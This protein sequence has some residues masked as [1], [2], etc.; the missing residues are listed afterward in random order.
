MYKI[1]LLIDISEDYGKSLL[2][3]VTKYSKENGPWIFCRMPLHYREDLSMDNL[4]K[5]A[6]EWKA[7]GIIAQ[8]YNTADIK[9]LKETNI[10]VIVEDFKERFTEFPNITG[11]YFETGQMGAKYFINKGYKNFAFYGFNDIVWSRERAEGYEDYIVKQGGKVH[12]FK[13]HKILSRELWYYKP[14]ALSKWLTS[15]P[16]PIA[17]M[18][19][20]DERAQYITGACKQSKIKIPEEVSV[21]G[22]DND[23]LT[24]NLSDPPL[25]SIGLD[26]E[27]GG[28]ETAKLM[29]FLIENKDQEP[30]D[31]IVKPTTIYTRQS[32]DIC[33]TTDAQIAMALNFIHQNIENNINV[34]DV[35][36]KVSISRRALE[37]RFLEVTG[38]AVY[39]YIC[40]LRIEKFSDKLLESEKSI[41]EIAIE[42]GFNDNK[43][44]SRL[45]KQINGC[46]PLQYRKANAK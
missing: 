36:K 38:S 1:I 12:F 37:K 10:P 8:L 4:I 18:A 34:I 16:K 30:Y 25:S 39:K 21:L 17:I 22:V 31:I 19:C 6:K 33:A 43:N 20:D 24:C 9:K 15:L 11:P 14:S 45:F 2:K 29:R 42:A 44:L 40:Q 46:S 26:V 13:P 35:L 7:D 3:G 32:T 5:F 27:K 23:E 28:Y 41:N